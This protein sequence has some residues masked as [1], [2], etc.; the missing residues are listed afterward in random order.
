MV[1]D[2]A[3]LL[4]ILE[5]TPGC[6]CH[7]RDWITFSPHTASNKPSAF[8]SAVLHEYLLFSAIQL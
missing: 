2:A 4:G 8:L 5:G 7:F 1:M 3:L 6:N